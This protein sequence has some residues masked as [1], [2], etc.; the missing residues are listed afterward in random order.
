MTNADDIK[1][2]VAPLVDKQLSPLGVAAMSKLELRPGDRVIDVGCGAGQTCQQLAERVGDTGTVLGVDISPAMIAHAANRTAA[3]NQVSI[4]LADAQTYPFPSGSAEAIFSRF[5]VMFFDDPVAAFS[6]LRCALSPEGRLA[7][8]C[9]RS[10][11]ENELDNVP[12]EVARPHLPNALSKG[13]EKDPPFSFADPDKVRSI[14]ATAGFD[15]ICVEPHTEAV[16]TGNVETMLDAALSVGTLGRIVRENPDLRQTV[17]PSVRTA[18]EKRQGKL[19][20]AVW[21]VTAAVPSSS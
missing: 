1:L 17:E 9:W 18:L 7:F 19:N 20:A 3:L 16:T 5:G 14:L 2:R 10:L 12:L 13:L 6:N 8:V 15:D 11:E 21:I 4:K